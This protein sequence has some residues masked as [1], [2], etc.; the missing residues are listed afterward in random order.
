M[1]DGGGRRVNR[2]DVDVVVADDSILLGR[3]WLSP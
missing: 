2:S 1:F 3:V